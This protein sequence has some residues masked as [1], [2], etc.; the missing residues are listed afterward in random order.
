MMNR[1]SK[2]ASNW[3]GTVLRETDKPRVIDRW[4]EIKSDSRVWDVF[5][6]PSSAHDFRPSPSFETEA[7]WP[8]WRV[9][10]HPVEAFDVL[11]RMPLDIAGSR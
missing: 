11:F 1:L 2:G 6:D 7:S 4:I 3:E 10:F 5:Y 9:R 8:M